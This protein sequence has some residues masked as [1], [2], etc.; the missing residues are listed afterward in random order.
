M[1]PR[2]VVRIIGKEE[3][4]L[5]LGSVSEK[6]IV[7]GSTFKNNNRSRWKFAERAKQQ[8]SDLDLEII[9]D[10]INFTRSFRTYAQISK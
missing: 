9:S 7:K 4:I 1:E 10:A 8:L 6:V 5:L 2:K 3:S